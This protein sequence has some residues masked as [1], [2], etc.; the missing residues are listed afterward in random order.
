MFCNNQGYSI[1]INE[2]GCHWNFFFSLVFINVLILLFQY[3]TNDY[4]TKPF[5]LSLILIISLNE[6]QLEKH[7]V[8]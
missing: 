7:N 5:I 8:V 6:K 4:E 3:I 2:Y 1:E